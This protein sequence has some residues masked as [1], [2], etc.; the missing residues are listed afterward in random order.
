MDRNAPADLLDTAERGYR[1]SAE[2]IERWHGR[3]RNGYAITPRFAPA[4]SPA[5]LD[6]AATLRREH[7]DVLVQTHIAETTSEVT[8]VHDL[9]PDRDGYFDVYHEHGLTG[10]GAV[11]AHGVHL[12]AGELAACGDS[13]TAIAHCPTSNLFL[14]SG[15][16][17]LHTATVDHRITVGLGSDVGAGTSFAP[18]VTAGAAH[19]VARLRGRTLDP[20]RA[21][22]LATLGGARALRLADRVGSLAAGHEADLVV[23]DLTATPALAR[24]TDRA[25]SLADVLFA[26]SVLGDERAVRAT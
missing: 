3:G 6:A 13:G 5:Q 7:P 2:L 14:G 10:P 26:L 22:Y 23:L 24:R 18:L 25:E 16:F 19:Q 15:L 9:F 12:S 21:W 8:Q 20:L 1:E 11:L 17:D 4:C